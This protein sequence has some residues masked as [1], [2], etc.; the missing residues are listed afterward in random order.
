M[1]NDIDSIV[2]RHDSAYI[3]GEK[4]MFAT[5][6]TSDGFD[7]E[8]HEYDPTI[9]LPHDQWLKL[10]GLTREQYERQCDVIHEGIREDWEARQREA[11]YRRQKWTWYG[12]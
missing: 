9:G 4:T 3:N 5:G 7:D 2:E 11:E 10:Q 12:F 1:N 8:H 6:D